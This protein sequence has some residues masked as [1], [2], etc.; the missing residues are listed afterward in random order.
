MNNGKKNACCRSG[1]WFGHEDPRNHALQIPSEHQSNQ[2]GKIAAVI[3]AL[4][5]IPPYQPVRILTD[6]KYVIEGLTSHLESW[7]NDRWINIK[8]AQWFRKVVH[9]IR[10]RSAKTSMQ[11]VKG[12]S[13]DQ[14][15][16]GSDA[17]AKQEANKQR[18]DSLNLEILKDFDIQGAK[19]PMLMQATAYKGILE[20]KRPEQR[21]TSEKNL[22][23]TRI[24]I[25]QVTG[26]TEMNAAIWLSTQSKT[27]R[28]IIQQF[29]YKMIHGTHLVRKY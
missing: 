21:N 17:L 3:A 15:N 26:K 5:T 24:A 18:P 6:S 19:L 12:H 1:V 22:Q 4:E 16:E 14:G 28:P 9:L 27:M 23:L 13:G 29:L 11:W 2:V 20:Q 8:N 7:E 10:Y 25:K